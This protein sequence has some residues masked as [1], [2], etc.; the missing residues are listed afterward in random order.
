MNDI[1]LT[2]LKNEQIAE[3]V[4]ELTLKAVRPPEVKAADFVRLPEIKPGQFANLE[5]PG[6]SDLILRRPFCLHSHMGGTVKVTFDI[7]GKGT[8]A[9]AAVKEGQKINA[10]LPLGNGFPHVRQKRIWLV[11]GGTGVLPLLAAAQALYREN[12]IFAFLGFKNKAAVIKEAEFNGLRLS[13]DCG[14]WMTRVATDDGSYGEKGFVTDLVAQYEHHE[15]DYIFACGPDAM[16]KNLAPYAQTSEIYVTL[17]SRMGCGVGAC[18]VCACKVKQGGEPE[19]KR[20]CADGPVFRF[21]E[22]FHDL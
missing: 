6:R 13:G 4:Y 15:P 5:I 2:I 3:G 10:L 11:G 22:V 14:C 21:Q 1:T 17:E 18:L 12:R 8:A 9:L 20:V 19:F 16:V 7:K